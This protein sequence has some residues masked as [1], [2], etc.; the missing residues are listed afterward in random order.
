MNPSHEQVLADIERLVG[1]EVALDETDTR[2]AEV[3]GVP[4]DYYFAYLLVWGAIEAHRNSADITDESP[5]LTATEPALDLAASLTDE[6]GRLAAALHDVSDR[7]STPKHAA[8]MLGCVLELRQLLRD[9]HPRH[10]A[11][12]RPGDDPV[13]VAGR[14]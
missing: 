10:G 4:P 14:G 13:E 12:L 2:I 9:M 8:R 3:L 6:I 1:T 5:R 7:R 11:P